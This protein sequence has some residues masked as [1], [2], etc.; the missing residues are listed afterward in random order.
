MRILWIVLVITC[1]SVCFSQT[2]YG[3]NPEAGKYASINGIKMYYE[4]YGTGMPV[5]LLHGNGGSIVGHSKRI[6]YFSKNYKVIAIDSRGHGKSI[7]TTSVL[8]YE[9][10]AKD[11]H[12]LLDKLKI[13]SAMIWGQSD[14]AIL[15]LLLAIHYPEKVRKAAGYAANLRPDTTAVIPE[16]IDWAGTLNKKVTATKDKQLFR[17]VT[18]QPHIPVSDLTKIR[19]PFMVMM[20]DRDLIQFSHSV[21][22]YKNIPKGFLFVMPGS[23][24]FGVYE[25]PEWFNMILGDFFRNPFSTTTTLEKFTH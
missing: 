9:M 8:T 5:V 1:S 13:D 19:A 6:E 11:I 17:L 3:N 4:I 14:G 23:T 18:E 16:I 2:P 20:G 21:E 10:M 15:A 22:I 7:D 25:H 12:D 24:H